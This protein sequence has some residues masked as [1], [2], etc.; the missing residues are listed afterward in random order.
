MSSFDL[1]A[2]YQ[3]IVGFALVIISKQNK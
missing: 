3:A 1:S 2:H